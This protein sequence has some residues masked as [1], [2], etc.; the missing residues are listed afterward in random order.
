MI[1][2]SDLLVNN[3]IHEHY[4]EQNIVIDHDIEFN[5]GCAS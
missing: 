2:L 5:D 3:K 1:F 4:E